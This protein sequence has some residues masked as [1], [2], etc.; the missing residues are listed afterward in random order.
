MTLYSASTVVAYWADKIVAPRVGST[1]GRPMVVTENPNP[2][3]ME[4]EKTGSGEGKTR[5]LEAQRVHRE[6]AYHAAQFH[7]QSRLINKNHAKGFCAAFRR[8]YAPAG[9]EVHAKR[10]PPAQLISAGDP[11]HWPSCSAPPPGS[12]QPERQ[13]PGA[14]KTGKSYVSPM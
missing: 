1:G 6:F 9:G 12:G 14:Q 10:V 11:T 8:F 2:G 4:S 7:D 3:Q 5:G 13:R